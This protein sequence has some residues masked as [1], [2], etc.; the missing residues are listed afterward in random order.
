MEKMTEQEIKSKQ[1]QLDWE[2]QCY[3]VYITTMQAGFTDNITVKLSGYPM[4][5]AGL[6]SDAQEC[7]E[8]ELYEK[9]RQ[10]LNQAKWVL[11]NFVVKV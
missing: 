10:T 8:H 11:F 7:I 4:V 9:A 1:E 5:V 6:L 2:L 3:G